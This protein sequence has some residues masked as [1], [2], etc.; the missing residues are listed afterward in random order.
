[1]VFIAVSTIKFFNF[2]VFHCVFYTCCCIRLE[3]SLMFA[4]WT[5]Y[6]QIQDLLLM[7]YNR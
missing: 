6:V 4:I 3:A 5:F 2:S 7:F 1:M